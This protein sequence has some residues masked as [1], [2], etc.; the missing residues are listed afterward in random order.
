M[1]PINLKN[2]NEK[3]RKVFLFNHL[4]HLYAN[5]G[6]R[7]GDKKDTGHDEDDQYSNFSIEFFNF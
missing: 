1:F 5:W 6:K 3:R 7:T 2:G 4:K